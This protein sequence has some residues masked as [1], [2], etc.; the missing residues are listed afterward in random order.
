MNDK[1]LVTFV[2]FAYNQEKFIREAIEGALSQT[3]S[4]LEIILSDDC[5]T[6]STF[7]IM[8]DMA[9]AY[10]GSHSVRVRACAKNRGWAEHINEVMAEVRGEFIVMA[11]GDDISK[12]IRVERLVQERLR[13]GSRFMCIYSGV[14]TMNRDG[15]IIQE[16]YFD[17]NRSG[18][19]LLDFVRY[20]Y[21]LGPS[22]A[23][24]SVVFRYF[25]PLLTDLRY[26][27]FIF[28]FR[29]LLLGGKVSLIKESLVFY[30]INVG[31]LCD[32]VGLSPSALF[33]LR[34]RRKEI[35]FLQMLKDLQK[36][37]TDKLCQSLV[38][39]NLSIVQNRILLFSN[40]KFHAFLVS[41]NILTHDPRG[42][43][44]I[45]RQFAAIKYPKLSHQYRRYKQLIKN[46]L[47]NP[48]V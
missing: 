13:N 15:I 30:R 22:Y 8:N 1:F 25:G 7:Q 23:F 14:S 6:D 9:S 38:E 21:S 33:L 40:D 43:I 2:L 47:T 10:S 41:L 32:E 29:T 4:P 5:S 3:Y 24:D 28:P 26:E 16:N 18:D 34:F 31:H 11:A 44:L 17:H 36:K 37:S 42:L 45:L 35:V 12:P 39:K 20:P 48:V 46:L 27:D 19:N